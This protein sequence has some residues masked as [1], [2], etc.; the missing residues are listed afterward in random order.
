MK[1][2]GGRLR[3]D[4]RATVTIELALVAPILAVM[5]IG[6]TDISIAYG[7]KL[8]LEQ[9]AQRAIEKVMQTT[10]ASTVAGT[11]S[12]EVVCQVNG[13]DGDG[14]CNSSPITTADITVSYR[15]ECVADD[16]TRTAQ[17][18]EDAATFDAF[19]CGEDEAEERYVSVN[20][21]D[22]YEPMFPIYFGDDED[23]E[24]HLAA[25]AGMRTQ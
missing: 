22:T 19:S 16:D 17:T 20:V 10:G 6:M 13:T 21:V 18:S 7:R 24:Y 1:M 9:G 2:F 5:V 12:N 8:S 23:G 11:I 14:N 25:T 15:L 4:A 3:R